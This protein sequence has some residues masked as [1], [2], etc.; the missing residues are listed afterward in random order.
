MHK[1]IFALLLAAVLMITLVACGGGSGLD[2]PEKFEKVLGEYMDLENYDKEEWGTESGSDIRVMY[3]ANEPY[4]LGTE[5][6]VL[7][8][9][10]GGE[11]ELGLWDNYI[12]GRGWTEQG[13]GRYCNENGQTIELELE[14]TRG[15]KEIVSEIIVTNTVTQTDAK[16]GKMHEEAFAQAPNFSVSGKITNDST[17][18]QTLAAFGQPLH[19]IY[20][21]SPDADYG[22]V[23]ILYLYGYVSTLTVR[24][25]I[26]AD[27]IRDVRIAPLM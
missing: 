1:K 16:T 20:S 3:S 15:N 8:F 14:K 21:V 18:A 27:R 9:E 22:Y 25:D 26:M 23:E 10:C 4:P 12:S 19:I 17:L 13:N 6:F 7:S 5:E 24:I 2:T 11:L